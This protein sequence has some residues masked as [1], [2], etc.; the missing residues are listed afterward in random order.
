GYIDDVHGWDFANGNRSVYD[1]ARNDRHGT[2][3]AGTIAATAGNGR[4]IAGVAPYVRIMPLKFLSRQGGTTSDA[5]KAIRYARRNGAD[6]INASFGGY[7]GGRALRDAIRASGLPLVA[8]AG[9]D[10]LNGDR[11]RVYPASY[12]LDNILSVTAVNNRGGLARFGNY[13]TR[14]VDVGAPGVDIFSTVPGGY[15]YLSGT[16]MAAPLATGVAALVSQQRPKASGARIV[17]IVK[18]S[19]AP[20]DSLRGKTVTGGMVNAARAVAD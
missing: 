9:N 18:R 14:T 10:G 3:V 8:A 7:F 5:I 4:G 19:A 20:L 2:H 12:D 17:R 16:S 6:V 11:Y 13:G 15:R 1:S